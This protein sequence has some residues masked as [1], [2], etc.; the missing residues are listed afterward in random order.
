MFAICN[1]P[2]KMQQ[3]ESH[4]LLRLPFLCFKKLQAASDGVCVVNAVIK[5]D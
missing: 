1:H 3:F 2:R 5:D 4:D